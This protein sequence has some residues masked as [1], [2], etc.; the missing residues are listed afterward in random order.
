[1]GHWVGGIGVQPFGSYPAADFYP[2][3]SLSPVHAAG[4]P[5]TD[6]VECGRKRDLIRRPASLF[7]GLRRLADIAAAS[8]LAWGP[9]EGRDEVLN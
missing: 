7:H 3:K 8:D 4:Y 9:D 6:R 5:Y 2:E 1:M